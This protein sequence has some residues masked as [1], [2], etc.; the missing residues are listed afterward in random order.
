MNSEKAKAEAAAEEA[1]AAADEFN[2]EI[3]RLLL[4]NDEVKARLAATERVL[5]ETFLAVRRLEVELVVAQQQ[6]AKYRESE[7]EHG[8]AADGR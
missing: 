3:R 5:D 6:L 8:A 1:A 2:A 4:E 7:G